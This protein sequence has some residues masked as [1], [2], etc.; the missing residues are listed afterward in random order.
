MQSQEASLVAVGLGGNLGEVA[1][2][3]RA[4]ARAIADLPTT[5]KFRLSHLYR[6]PAVSP[7]PQPEFLNG[8]ALFYT[9]ATARHLLAELQGI[10]RKLGKKFKAKEAPRPLDLDIIFFG[11]ERHQCADLEIP[12]PRWQ[13]RLF[14]VAPLCELLVE[15]VL[16]EGRKIDLLALRAQLESRVA[17]GRMEVV[18]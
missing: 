9:S 16:P 12:H 10:E 6:N 2:T 14:V 18:N 1:E 8:M 11:Q 4:A 13:E 5:F 17:G 7:I 3:L 15:V